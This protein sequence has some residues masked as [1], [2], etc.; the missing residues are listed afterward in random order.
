MSREM[1]EFAAA[2]KARRRRS[3]WSRPRRILGMWARLGMLAVVIAVLV[4]LAFTMVAKAIRPYREASVQN[5]QL[6]E[7]RRQSSALEAE[8]ALLA[9]RIA[10]LKTPGGVASEARSMGYLRPGEIPIVVEIAP[11]QPGVKSAVP[12]LAAL[13]APVLPHGE[14]AASRFWSHLTGH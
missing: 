14:N 11:G 1:D 2:R 10:Y 3:R 9:R 4:L 8:N 13:T 7:T 5:T 6:S 12:D